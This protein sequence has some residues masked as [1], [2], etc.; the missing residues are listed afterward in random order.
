MGTK[1][2]P[3]LRGFPDCSVGLRRFTADPAEAEVIVADTGE[4]IAPADQKKV[5]TVFESRKGNRGTGL[6]LPVSQKILQEHGGDIDLE[7]VE[8]QGS[9]FSLRFPAVFC[10][11]ERRTQVLPG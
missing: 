6:G 10:D 2:A 8:G 4:G 1:K 7:S 3:H 9:R 5:F 11:N